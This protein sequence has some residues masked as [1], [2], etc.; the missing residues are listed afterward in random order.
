[1]ALGHFSV[2]IGGHWEDGVRIDYQDGPLRCFAI[3]Q[4]AMLDEAFDP[5]LQL[6]PPHRRLHPHE[7][8]ILATE[9]LPAFARIIST[10]HERDRAS[11]SKPVRRV[12]VGLSD[13]LD[14]GERFTRDTLPINTAKEWSREDWDYLAYQLRRDTPLLKI[15]EY[16]KREV[17]EVETMADRIEIPG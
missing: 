1:M 9:N 13:I 12:E 6:G 14:N 16:L 8:N 10:R 17:I 5:L 2:V 15:A 3:F 7:W 11:T 4:W